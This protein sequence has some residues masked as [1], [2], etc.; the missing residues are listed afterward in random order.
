MKPNGVSQSLLSREIGVSC[1]RIDATV[2]GR[3]AITAA[4]ALRLAKY[5]FSTVPELWMNL[6]LSYELRCIRAKNW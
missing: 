5:Y 4:I 2:R 1:G 3:S 6:Q